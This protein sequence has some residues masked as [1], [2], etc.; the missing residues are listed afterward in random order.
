MSLRQLVASSVTPALDRV[1]SILT[2]LICLID[3][4]LQALTESANRTIRSNRIKT[5][6][7][8][9]SHHLPSQSLQ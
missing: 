1:P 7:L 6:S 2:L 4:E 5:L 3:C 9:G 8:G